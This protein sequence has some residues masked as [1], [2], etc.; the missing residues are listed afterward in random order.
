VRVD[1]R[2]GH[3]QAR[4]EARQHGRLAEVA[5]GPQGDAQGE[6]VADVEHRVDGAAG[7]HRPDRPVRQLRR[8]LAQELAGVGHGHVDLVGVHAHQ[9]IR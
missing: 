2:D 8:V 6:V 3:G 7:I 5:A 9:S 4:G 1:P